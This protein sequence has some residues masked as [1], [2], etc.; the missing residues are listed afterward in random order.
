LYA[1][2]ATYVATHHFNLTEAT[3]WTR[4]HLA[5]NG[6]A[7]N[8]AAV[9]FVV[10]GASFGGA[11]LHGEPPPSAHQIA[12]AFVHNLIDRSEAAGI[13]LDDQASVDIRRWFGCPGNLATTKRPS[14]A[15]DLITSVTTTRG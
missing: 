14:S 3:R 4:D 15:E 10:R 2:L 12:A 11:P 9:G 6:V 8:R 13:T 7:A 1:G 5:A